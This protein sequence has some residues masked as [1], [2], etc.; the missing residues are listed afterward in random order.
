MVAGRVR[1]PPVLQYAMSRRFFKTSFLKMATTNKTAPTFT[2][3][4]CHNVDGVNGFFVLR[5]REHLCETLADAVA[6]ADRFN[7]VT[8]SK[9]AYL[10]TATKA[11]PEGGYHES[12]VYK[13]IGVSP[14]GQ[15]HTHTLYFEHIT[16]WI[17]E[18]EF[19]SLPAWGENSRSELLT[20]F[21]SSYFCFTPEKSK[22]HYESVAAVLSNNAASL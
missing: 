7:E 6:L 3:S 21:D 4:L 2:Y 10:A 17:T 12:V 11:Y 1:L 20:K 9:R 15:P 5:N 8:N 14:D 19:D 13:A 22:T 16:H 18:E